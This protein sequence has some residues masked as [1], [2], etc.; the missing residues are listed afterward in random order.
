MCEVTFVVIAHSKV[1]GDE[2]GQG[3]PDLSVSTDIGSHQASSMAVSHA[4]T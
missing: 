4:E 2:G 1:T 3:H